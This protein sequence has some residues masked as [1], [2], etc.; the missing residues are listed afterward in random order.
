MPVR[1]PVFNPVR[2]PVHN[3]STP[4]A[5]PSAIPHCKHRWPSTFPRVCE[6]LVGSGDSPT[7]ADVG[8]SRGV[9]PGSA[10]HAFERICLLTRDLAVNASHFTAGVNPGDIHVTTTVVAR[11]K[12][13]RQEPWCT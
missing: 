4:S 13:A 1:N 12:C 6:S 7:I 5:T 3:P 11:R 8:D 10:L 2:N 9:T